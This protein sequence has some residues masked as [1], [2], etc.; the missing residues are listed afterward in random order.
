MITYQIS[1]TDKITASIGEQFQVISG[2]APL[3]SPQGSWEAY[4]NLPDGIELQEQ[5][6]A[7]ED[8]YK[9]TLKVVHAM[10]S[11]TLTC[12]FVDAGNNTTEEYTLTVEAAGSGSAGNG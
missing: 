10:P 8:R 5:K 6:P 3:K 12:G 9:F 4:I 11:G 7:E 1:Q 2:R